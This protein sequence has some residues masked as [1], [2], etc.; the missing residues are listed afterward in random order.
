MNIPHSPTPDWAVSK[1]K[2]LKDNCE[3]EGLE[4][5][6]ELLAA[7]C[8]TEDQD[9]FKHEAAWAVLTEGY[10]DLEDCRESARRYFSAA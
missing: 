9:K 1:F 2:I 6:L 5:A 8:P 3:P 10:H 4:A 7:V